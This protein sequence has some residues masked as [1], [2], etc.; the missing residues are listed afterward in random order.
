VG[1]EQQHMWQLAGRYSALGIEMAVA[2]AMGTLGG[3]W[4][5]KRFDASPYLLL[6]GF[7]VGVGAAVV[8]LRRTLRI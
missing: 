5:D 3:A 7:V 8:S 4:L 6:A 1:N 2:V